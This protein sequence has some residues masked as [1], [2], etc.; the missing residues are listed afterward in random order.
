M[1][2]NI[3]N[4]QVPPILSAFRDADR[5]KDGFLSMEEYIK[6]FKVSTLTFEDFFQMC[7]CRYVV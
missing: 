4:T 3:A 5:D 6:V 7:T 1:Q 2:K